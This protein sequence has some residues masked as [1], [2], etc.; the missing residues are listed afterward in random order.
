LQF[1][2]GIR[3]TNKHSKDKLTLAGVIKKEVSEES[4]VTNWLAEESFIV[5][6]YHITIKYYY[7]YYYISI[8]DIYIYVTD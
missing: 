4:G 6:A 3:V 5:H 2:A 7:Y 8:K 1:Y